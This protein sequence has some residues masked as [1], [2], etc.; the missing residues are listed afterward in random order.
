MSMMS[1]C[2]SALLNQLCLAEIV[3]LGT[4]A[5]SG[6]EPERNHFLWWLADS[7]VSSSWTMYYKTNHL[8]F[9]LKASS[10]RSTIK[11]FEMSE[12][13]KVFWISFWHCYIEGAFLFTQSVTKY[14]CDH[15]FLWDR[16]LDKLVFSLSSTPLDFLLKK[17]SKTISLFDSLLSH[18]QELSRK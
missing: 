6:L 7:W 4:K 3:S 1:G 12:Q 16:A 15:I 14:I 17:L 13:L 10:Q 11:D 8:I 5:L 9:C 18:T 2:I